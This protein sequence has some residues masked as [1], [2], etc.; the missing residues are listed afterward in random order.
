MSRAGRRGGSGRRNMRG[1]M[2]KMLRRRRNG[3]GSAEIRLF[4]TEQEGMGP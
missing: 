4:L 3:S 1:G 2:R